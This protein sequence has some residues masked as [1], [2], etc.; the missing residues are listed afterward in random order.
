M[1]EGVM[2]ACMAR[3]GEN[4][5]EVHDECVA[6]TGAPHANV[7]A[8]GAYRM[9]ETLRECIKAGGI[10]AL[11]TDHQK[12]ETRC[13]EFERKCFNET[14]GSGEQQL[15]DLAS[16]LGREDAVSMC[17]KKYESSK[18]KA[19]IMKCKE[20][21]EPTDD[22]VK[23]MPVFLTCS[24]ITKNVVPLR[25]CMAPRAGGTI[26]DQRLV[27]KFLTSSNFLSLE[28]SEKIDSQLAES[29]LRA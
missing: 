26:E 15:K 5:T 29:Q 2:E 12:N 28:H 1:P 3:F 8:N 13:I 19:V 6:G 16:C 10:M 18:C 24:L 20:A 4:C 17:F 14:M 9:P 25:A 27:L 22:G 21:A 23:N 7:D 11:C